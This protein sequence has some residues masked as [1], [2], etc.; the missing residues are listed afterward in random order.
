MVPKVALTKPDKRTAEKLLAQPRVE[1]KSDIERL[2]VPVTQPRSFQ[3]LEGTDL[4]IGGE[5]MKGFY[6]NILPKETNKIIGK[7]GAKVGKSEIA[8]P[9]PSPS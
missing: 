8:I 5:G 1:Q 4:K 9:R 7:Y 2:D 6:D 3:T